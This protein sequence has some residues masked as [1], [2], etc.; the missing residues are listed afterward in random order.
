[1]K[2]KYYFTFGYEFLVTAV[3]LFFISPYDY[4]M[5]SLIIA[6]SA[7]CLL[8]IKLILC[9]I[10][11]KH[12]LVPV[13]AAVLFAAAL[14]TDM[15][16]TTPGT[17]YPLLCLLLAEFFEEACG[18]RWFI[19]L[20]LAAAV[21]TAVITR[22]AVLCITVA[23][24][25]YAA[26]AFVYILMARLK[27]SDRQIERRSDEIRELT[28]RME[29]Q[30]RASQSLEAVARLTERNRLAARIHDDIG[31]GVSGSIMLLEAALLKLK[32]D[33]EKAKEVIV[34]AT[35]NLRSSVDD[36]RGTLREE[37]SELGQV[38]LAQIKSSLTKFGAEHPDIRTELRTD[39][40]TEDIAPAIWMCIQDNLQEALTN[41]LKHSNGDLFSVAIAAKN[42]L[43]QVEFA[44]NGSIGPVGSTGGIGLISMEERCAMC[45][46]RFFTDDDADGFRIRMTFPMKHMDP[47][48]NAQDDK[49][50]ILREA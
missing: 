18:V 31:H 26:A 13:T 36:I 39:S 15:T 27:S 5:R 3:C 34:T 19:Q 4:S 32:S 6:L 25:V 21:L 43:L 24:V 29:E 9:L 50:V 45:G 37:R 16:L 11:K 44:D 20:S 8:G 48:T 22:P 17:F 1:V 10:F 30:R 7:F 47:A 46:G 49:R 35:E 41:M 14:I 33:P 28:A 40:T 12:I 38:G 42:K 2:E 23:V